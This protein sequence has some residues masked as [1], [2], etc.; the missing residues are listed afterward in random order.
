MY[1]IYIINYT[2][3]KYRMEPIMN[4]HKSIADKLNST[5]QAEQN[6][7]HTKVAS[8]EDRFQLA[9]Q[10]LNK[11]NNETNLPPN[12]I[13]TKLNS[14]PKATRATFSLL[15]SD[16]ELI[17]TVINRLWGLKLYTNRSELIRSMIAFADKLS[18][19]ALI[20]ACS[21]VEKLNVG[22]PKKIK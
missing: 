10:M 12:N 1:N 2:K 4:K 3:Y 16:L 6:M 14:K 15:E 18:D 5:M 13:N 17:N 11:N 19:K 20:E 7:T 9:E 21:I 8:I 22:A